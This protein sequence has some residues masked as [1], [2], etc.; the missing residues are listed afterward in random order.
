MSI[1][2]LITAA[3]RRVELIRS[4]KAVLSKIN[5]KV[6]AVDCDNLSPALFFADKKFNVPLVGDKKYV[7]KVLDICD[8]ENVR[9]IVPTIDQELS[10]W[11]RKKNEIEKLGISVSISPLET[12]E[13]CGDKIKTYEFFIKHKL[14]FPKSYTVDTLP[15]NPEFPLF[16]KPRMGRGSDD[17]YR[18]DNFKILKFYSDKIENP[19]ISEY[20]RGKEFTTDA[21]FSKKGELISC[22]HRYRLVVRAGVSDRGITFKNENLTDYIYKLGKIMKFEGA[23]NIQGKIDEKKIYFFE[24]NPRFSGGIQLTR[25]AG[26]NFAELLIEELNGKEL[27]KNLYNYLDSI[28]MVSYEESIFLDNKG[29]IIKTL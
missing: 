1:T 13:I 19:I 29:K 8:S 17:T 18:V 23:V 22:V 26:A 16:I 6:I 11:A 9:L 10:I 14:P 28:T 7:K 21:F 27:K 2:V 15:E 24:I 20:L 25:A 3:S 12:V 4:F 5:G